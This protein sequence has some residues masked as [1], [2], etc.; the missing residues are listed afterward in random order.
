MLSDYLVFGIAG[1]IGAALRAA[2]NP[3]QVTLSRQTLGDVVLGGLIGVF[4][5]D[6]SPV[7]FDPAMPLLKRAIGVAGVSWLAGDVLRDAIRRW[8]GAKEPAAR[9]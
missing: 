1:L 8:A 7:Q 4:F 5:M 9:P 2:F 3:E 6:M